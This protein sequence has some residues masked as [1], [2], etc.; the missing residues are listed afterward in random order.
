MKSYNNILQPIQQNH[1]KIE[2]KKLLFPLQSHIKSEIQKEIIKIAHHIIEA[3]QSIIADKESF[4]D[5]ENQISDSLDKKYHSNKETIRLYKRPHLENENKNSIEYDFE[6]DFRHI[7]GLESNSRYSLII[8]CKKLDGDNLLNTNYIKY[9]MN[10]FLNP[11][12]SSYY[13]CQFQHTHL[14][15]GY[16]VKPKIDIN[17]NTD[18][19]N[20]SLIKHLQ[21]QYTST[22]Q[23]QLLMDS[24]LNYEFV[25]QS[26]HGDCLSNICSSNKIINNKINLYH[27]FIDFSN[28]IINPED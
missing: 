21:P 13:H 15:I 18:E 22:Q 27:I 25:Y 14:M 4:Y 19:I 23:L 10:R 5:Y 9:G 7:H 11:E 28:N 2:D 20:K 17:K 8:E 3:C 24:N 6:T 1:D 12:H 16:M 26:N